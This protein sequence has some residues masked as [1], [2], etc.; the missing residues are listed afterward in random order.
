MHFYVQERKRIA[1]KEDRR[2]QE[3]S[4]R[5][6]PPPEDN[7]NNFE[8]SAFKAMGAMEE[9]DVVFGSSDEI[10]LDSQVQLS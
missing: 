8:R 1:V 4:S 10:N 3:M 6:N 9:G 5:Q 7:S 2:I